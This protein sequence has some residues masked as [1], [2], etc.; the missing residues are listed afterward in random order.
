MDLSPGSAVF[1]LPSFDGLG[2]FFI[3]GGLGVRIARPSETPARRGYEARLLFVGDP[4]GPPIEVREDG[5]LTLHRWAQ[6]ISARHPGGVEEAVWI[7]G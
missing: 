5:R 3:A 7:G 4:A 6:W 2:H 1:L